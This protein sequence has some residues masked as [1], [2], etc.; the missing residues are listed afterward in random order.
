[1]GRKIKLVK[2][3]TDSPAPS[4][5]RKFVRE[6]VKVQRDDYVLEVDEEEVTTHDFLQIAKDIN[7]I[8]RKTYRAGLQR[9]DEI[10]PTSEMTPTE[11]SAVGVT[12]SFSNPMDL[13]A[14]FP[15]V[16]DRINNGLDDFHTPSVEARKKRFRYASSIIY[17]VVNPASVPDIIRTFT[18]PVQ[19]TSESLWTGYTEFGLEGTAFGDAEGIMDYIRSTVG[20]TWELNGLR[21]AM[22]GNMQ[23]VPNNLTVDQS[24]DAIEAVLIDGIYEIP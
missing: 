20:T 15:D 21:E 17:N 18:T 11:K 1:M 10:T 2:K 19:G 3:K 8:D 14:Q 5:K 4:K 9:F 13:I 24:I 7:K 12:F 6:K 22:T 16:R 23:P